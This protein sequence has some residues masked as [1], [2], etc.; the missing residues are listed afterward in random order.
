MKKDIKKNENKK[1]TPKQKSDKKTTKKIEKL[2]EIIKKKWLINGSKTLLLILIIIAIYIGVNILLKNVVLPEIDF[3]KDKIYSLSQ[4]TR[5]KLKNLEKDVNITLINYNDYDSSAINFIERY[6]ELNGHIKLEKIDDLSSRPDL[7][8]K[9]SLDETSK[10]IVIECGE[11]EK[12]LSES[13]L[14]TYDYSTYEQIDTTEEAITNAIIDVIT[15]EKSKIYFMNNHV[16]YN[17]QYFSTIIEEM[18]KEAN[19]V[20]EV[21]ILA[22]G[23]IPED[24]DCLILTTLKEDITEQERDKI[25]EYINNGGELLLMCGPNIINTN[26]ENFQKVLDEYGITIE[27]GVIFEGN[28]ANMIAGY[29][30]F[31]IEETQSTSLTE[32]LNMKMNLCLIDTGKINFQEDKLEELGVEYEI[33]AT[34]TEQA[35]LRTDLNQNSVTRTQKDSE[36]EDSTIAAIATKTIEEGK[37]S[38]LVIYANELFA[39]N[40]PVQINGYQMYTV[41]L[42]NNKDM[43]LNSIAYLNQREDTITIRKTGES[44]RYTVTEQQNIIIISIIFGL[45]FLIILVGI[46]VWIKRRRKK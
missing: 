24:C 34:T 7:M 44:V 5:D 35:F 9:Y 15:E 45:P 16:A 14:Y 28:T 2:G 3:S 8:Q 33:L 38:Q 30:D 23:K 12:T 43:I 25:I 10:L 22:T 39:M 1:Q 17:S 26:L 11:N 27:N 18:E 21:D 46:I 41:S 31:I 42:Y 37:T 4:E 20:E 40:M 6:V 13:D 32:K 36:P 19:E 29:P